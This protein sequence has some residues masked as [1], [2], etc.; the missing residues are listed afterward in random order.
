MY[1]GS[2][3]SEFVHLAWRR[4]HPDLRDLKFPLL[5]DI[6]RELSEALGILNAKEG[7]CNRATFITDPEGI[8]RYASVHDLEIGRNPQE[9]LRVLDALQ[10]GELTPCNWKKGEPVLKVA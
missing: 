2:T 6:R 7:V 9:I 4:D 10:T 3:D 8:I 1:G 5:S